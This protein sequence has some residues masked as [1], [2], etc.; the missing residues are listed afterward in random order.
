MHR[1]LLAVIISG[2]AVFAASAQEII[3]YGTI[4]DN[5]T[6]EPLVGASVITEDRTGV[7][8]DLDG[9]Y[10]IKLSASEHT[11]TYSFI[12]YKAKQKTIDLS[13]GHPVKKDVSLSMK[14]Q[15]LDIVVISASQYEKSIAEETVSMEVI[16]KELIKNNNSTDLGEAVKKTPGVWFRTAK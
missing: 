1:I 4:T 6:N 10:Q 16:S 5:E 9:K 13:T 15:Q 11:I 2:L 8:T 3:L 7:T 14:S 12:G